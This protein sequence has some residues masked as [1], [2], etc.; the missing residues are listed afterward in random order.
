MSHD[1]I[2][3]TRTLVAF[4]A[5]GQQGGSLVYY[6]RKDHSSLYHIQAVTR[7][8]SKQS[9]QNLKFNNVEALQADG[10]DTASLRRVM[11]GAYMAFAMTLPKFDSED[12]RVR[13]IAQGRAIA[14]A[15]FE[16]GIS[17][18]KYQRVDH[19]DAKAEVE[20]YMYDLPIRSIFY[21]PGWFMQN[22]NR[23]LAPRQNADGTWSIVNI[24]TPQTSLPLINQFEE[25]GKFLAP[26]LVGPKKFAG[27]TLSSAERFYSYQGIV[28][29]M[30]NV[31]GECGAVFGERLVEMMLYFE[32]YG[33]Y[34]PQGK[35]EVD[36]MAKIATGD[37]TTFDEYLARNPLRS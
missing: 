17:C 26:V 27:Q 12:A 15:A 2:N 34:G 37:L 11:H 22:F 14:D 10:H 9:A 28:Q 18:G 7:D 33:Y 16:K 4:G 1:V 20:L 32:E 23:H 8:P 25:M 5:T 29:S 3:N 13:E 30:S 19:F 31:W 6:V 36:R 35:Q 24:V 21:S